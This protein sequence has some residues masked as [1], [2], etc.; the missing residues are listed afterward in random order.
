MNKPDMIAFVGKGF[1]CEFWLYPEKRWVIDRLS[2]VEFGLAVPAANII[3]YEK[4]RPR[5]NKPQVLDDWSWLPDGFVWRACAYDSSVKSPMFHKLFSATSSKCLKVV[6][7]IVWAGC[8]GVTEEYRE[9][10]ESVGME[11]FEA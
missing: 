7:N 6:S 5:L 1:D 4:F 10:G 3:A 2:R 8:I 9:W 11:V